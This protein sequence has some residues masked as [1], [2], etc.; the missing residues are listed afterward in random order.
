[1]T[2][3]V[4]EIVDEDDIDETELDPEDI[5]LI[6]EHTRV[7]RGTVV[8]ALIASG[9]FVMLFGFVLK[10]VMALS[11]ERVESAI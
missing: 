4:E 11:D 7:S 5:E 9:W 10:A 6:I 2:A 8:K 3:Q 1:M